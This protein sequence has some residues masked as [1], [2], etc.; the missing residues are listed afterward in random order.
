MYLISNSVEEEVSIC[1]TKQ[2][3]LLQDVL[4]GNKFYRKRQPAKREMR[5]R[6]KKLGQCVNYSGH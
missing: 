4:Q 6:R 3:T 2:R 1:L 5:V